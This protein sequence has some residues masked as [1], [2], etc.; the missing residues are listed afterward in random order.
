MMAVVSDNSNWNVGAVMGMGGG[1]MI[2]S[3]LR[4]RLLLLSD[5]FFLLSVGFWKKCVVLVF[6]PS[7]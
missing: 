4:S 5:P 6:V 2:D 7:H 3:N 1:E